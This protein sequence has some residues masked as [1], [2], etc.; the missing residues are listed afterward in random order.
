MA[1]VEAS[2]SL[3][4]SFP[5]K[6]DVAI[7]LRGTLG[8]VVWNPA[9]EGVVDRLL[10]VTEASHVPPPDRCKMLEITS[11]PYPG[12]CGHM[13]INFLTDFAE[14]IRDDRPPMVTPDDI[15]GAVRVA[16]AFYR[17]VDSGKAETVEKN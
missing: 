16:D 6:R 7:S 1:F 17:S 14:A 3:P 13:G 11:K 5:G 10:L 8:D 9:W 4:D 2:Y 15:L 12:Y